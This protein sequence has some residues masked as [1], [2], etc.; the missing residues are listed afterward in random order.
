MRNT[1][2]SFLFNSFFWPACAAY[3]TI[4]YPLVLFSS[5]GIAH[6]FGYR[7]VTNLLI[8]CLRTLAKVD[9]QVKNLE[10]LRSAIENGPVIIGC[11]HQS[12]WETF[13][14]SKLF[15]SLSIVVKKE[16]LN[17]PVAGLYFKKLNCIAIDRSSPVRAIR[18]LMKFGKESVN[19][20]SSI[21]IFANGTRSS[22]DEEVEFKS[23][24]YA[25][26]KYLNVPVVPANVDSGKCWPRRS[27]S[28]NPGTIHLRFGKPIPPGL[29][30]Q[31]FIKKFAELLED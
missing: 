4:L 3:L 29:A 22:V 15:E 5:G 18:D 26:Y 20:G 30:K 24:I 9:Y 17:V 31:D 23:G 1:F 12:T 6:R 7:Q 16:L 27:F 13:I 14:F 2:R 28:K 19:N 8:F 21:L 11:N 10:V 25:M